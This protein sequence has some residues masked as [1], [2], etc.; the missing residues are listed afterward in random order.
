[1][2]NPVITLLDPNMVNFQIVSLQATLITL[3]YSRSINMGFN[4]TIQSAS[5]S[6]GQANETFFDVIDG[7][8]QLLTQFYTLFS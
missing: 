2:E 6:W 1:M 8:Y 4:S 3:H 7:E 5:I